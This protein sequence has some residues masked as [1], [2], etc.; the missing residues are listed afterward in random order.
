MFERTSF[1]S[2]LLLSF[3]LSATAARADHL[4]VLNGGEGTADIHDPTT[5]NPIATAEVGIGAFRAVGIP[6]K[7]NAPAKF[8][9]V[10]PASVT[11]LAE[12]FSAL[13]NVE[14]APAAL[15]DPAGV[16][17]SMDGARLIVASGSGVFLLDTNADT[18]VAFIPTGFDVAGVAVLPDSGAYVFEDGSSRVQAID[19]VGNSL[20]KYAGALPAAATAWSVSPDGSQAFALAG[21]GLFNLRTAGLDSPAPA[22]IAQGST[23]D[24]ASRL[25][26][27][28][29]GRYFVER[30]GTLFAVTGFDWKQER[31]VADVASSSWAV[32]PSGDSVYVASGGRLTV[33]GANE[34]SRA[35][36]AEPTAVEL[37]APHIQ[38]G[39]TLEIITPPGLRVAGGT[40]FEL[41]ARARDANGN[42]Q[43]RVPVFAS[44]IVPATP[45]VRCLGGVTD[46]DGNVALECEMGEVT[47]AVTV[48]ITVSDGEGRSAQ[49]LAIR[50]LPPTEFEGLGAISPLA[51]SVRTSSDFT[52]MVQ[53]T[54]NRVP[55][56]AV[57]VSLGIVPADTTAVFCATRAR[58]ATDGHAMFPCTTGFVTVKTTVEI[59]VTDDIGNSLLFVIDVDPDAIDD[60]G[61]SKISGDLQTVVQ[62]APLPEPLVIRVF[63]DG[64]PLPGQILNVRT[65]GGTAGAPTIGNPPIKCPILIRTDE[66]GFANIVCRAQNVFGNT[67]AGVSVTYLSTAQGVAKTLE[68]AFVVRIVTSAPNNVTSLTLLTEGQVRAPVGKPT[69]GLI[70][71]RASQGVGPLALGIQG[72]EIHF[73]AAEGP[74]TFDPSI[75]ETDVAGDATT[76]ITMG[77]ASP[78]RA[79]VNIGFEPGEALRIVNVRGDPGDL[80]QL[81]IIQGDNQSGVPGQ[82][83]E[84]TAMVA[85]AADACGSFVPAEGFQ[86]RVRPSFMATLRNVT[87]TSR[88]GGV[89]ALATLGQYGGPFQ[90]T[91]SNG[92]IG[93]VFNLAVNLPA[94]QLRVRSGNRQV[95]QAG[96][97]AEQPLVVQAL[98][99]TG[100]GVGGIRVDFAVT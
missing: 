3:A 12:D 23:A 40:Y 59:T 48:Q 42:L 47:E 17:L 43:R 73:T 49:P 10:A 78:N 54:R 30:E 98:G 57:D 16:A 88:S 14:L 20:G 7:A 8:F 74:V 38:Q 34:T 35:L 90:V 94:N 99:T 13:N 97:M 83:L 96:Q 24:T 37:V 21:D 58:T 46:P 91:V 6:A 68:R 86:W 77:C 51:Q 85:R 18:I 100:F 32:S 45:S 76:S 87:G 75:V 62:G 22:V 11:V 82:P 15:A 25:A 36:R 81:I 92:D 4:I 63:E 50:A 61:I 60:N 80:S 26:V 64:E 55:I 19:L 28:N 33:S 53:A 56:A 70:R 89:S 1:I 44:L 41:A 69:P 39:G 84:D 9:V 66:N 29:S 31:P 2:C 93:A 79:T 95:V 72:V 67:L 27:T 5:L 52:L 71:V 65:F